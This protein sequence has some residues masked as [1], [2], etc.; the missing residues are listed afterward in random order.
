MTD[1]ELIARLAT[2]AT[3]GGTAD[4]E[5]LR[6]AVARLEESVRATPRRIQP[7]RIAV[8]IG[9]SGQWYAYGESRY[10]DRT[11]CEEALGQVSEAHQACYIITADVPVP[12]V[13]E[14]AGEIAPGG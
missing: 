9:A 6:S 11:L 10:D 13:R 14:I 12:E 5:V 3:H 8:A 2:L 7:V 4:D 1:R